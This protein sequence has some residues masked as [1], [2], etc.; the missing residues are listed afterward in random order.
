MQGEW[1]YARNAPCRCCQAE[2]RGLDRD[3]L[4]MGLFVGAVTGWG[5]FALALWRLA[6]GY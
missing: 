3:F 5:L 6:Y 4:V 2:A 1:C